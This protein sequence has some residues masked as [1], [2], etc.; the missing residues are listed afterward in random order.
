MKSNNKLSS[1]NHVT[2]TKATAFLKW[3][4]KL[5]FI[6]WL[7]LGFTNLQA[8]TFPVPSPAL[9]WQKSYWPTTHPSTVTQTREQSGEDWYYTITLSKSNG[10][11]NGWMCGGYNTYPE[12]DFIESNGGC[13][14]LPVKPASEYDFS[15]FETPGH[16]K[17]GVVN[18]ISFVD[19]DGNRLWHKN[20]LQGEIT[21]I[22]QTSDGNFLA[23]GNTMS[24]R[25][26]FNGNQNLF[27]NQT[28]NTQINNYFKESD[29]NSKNTRKICLIKIDPQGNLIWQKLFGMEDFVQG[30]S[31]GI[32]KLA[33]AS[34]AYG[35]DVVEIDEKYY[36]T[37]KASAATSLTDYDNNKFNTKAFI[38]KINADGFLLDKSFL[39]NASLRYHGGTIAYYKD[40]SNN[41][42]IAVANETKNE[43]TSEYSLEFNILD[44]A[45]TVL[46][47]FYYN[48]ESDKSKRVWNIT[49]NNNGNLLVPLVHNCGDCWSSGYHGKGATNTLSVCK[50]D[51]TT[52]NNLA[53]FPKYF[54]YV[55]AYDLRMGI[56]NTKDGGFA[57]VTSKLQPDFNTGDFTK[58][59]TS[60]NNS[61]GILFNYEKNGGIN[62]YYPGQEGYEFWQTNTYVAKCA[63]DGTLE[64]DKNF[65][66][67]TLKQA[68]PQANWDYTNLK[69]DLK[70]AEC[71]YAIVQND[72]ES[73][74]LAGNNSANFDDDYLVKINGDCDMRTNNFDVVGTSYPMTYKLTTNE[75]WN[76]SKKVLG[77]VIIPYGKTLTI[78]GT[79]TTNSSNN[80][81]STTII[82]FADSRK[83]NSR[84]NIIVEPGGELII[85]GAMLTSLIS[86]A[87]TNSKWDGILVEGNQSLNQFSTSN[88]GYVQL[89][90]AIIENAINGI[91]TSSYTFGADLASTINWSKTGGG[92][93]K[94]NNTIFR[95]NKRHVEFMAYK[96]NITING[97][98]QEYDNKSS[99]SN[100]NF[101]LE[102]SNYINSDNSAQRTMVT[103]WGVKGV[104]FTACDFKNNTGAINADKEFYNRGIGIYTLDASLVVDGSINTNDCS[105]IK[106]G[107]FNDL[108]AGIINKWSTGATL[109]S[110]YRYLDFK[111][112]D[113]SIWIASGNTA[114][115]H[116]SKFD[117]NLPANYYNVAN[118]TNSNAFNT[119]VVGI[120]ANEMGAYVIENNEFT[121]ASK[122]DKIIVG[123]ILHNSDV[124]PTGAKVR[125]NTYEGVALGSQTQ[126]NNFGLA[127]T[128]NKYIDIVTSAVKM[129]PFTTTSN[130]PFFGNCISVSN[131]KDYKNEFT[132]MASNLSDD[133]INHLAVTKTYVVAPT[134]INPPATAKVVNVNVTTCGTLSNTITEKEACTATP[135]L[136]CSN[137]VT[138]PNDAKTK[139]SLGKTQIINLNNAINSGNLTETG[140]Q[141][142]LAEK[143]YFEREVLQARGEVLW[144]F[145]KMGEIDSTVNSTDSIIAFLT[146]ENDAVSKKLL[147]ATYYLAGKYNDANNVLSELSNDGSA[148]MTNFIAYYTLL[149]NANQVNR[150]I[151]QLTAG[152][153]TNMEQIA[154]S[155]S[156]AAESAKGILTLVKGNYYDVYIERAI[157][158]GGLGKTGKI[159]ATA[160]ENTKQNTNNALTV[161]PNPAQNSIFIRLNNINTTEENVISLIDVTGKIVLTKKTNNNGTIEIDTQNLSNGVY[162]VQL[163]NATLNIVSKI[164]ITH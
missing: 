134:A 97:K 95:N 36:I 137:I 152:E 135:S 16:R 98:T 139:L 14:D 52:G 99:F 24:T 13:L 45:L 6:L 43:T 56:T 149:I 114:T 117:L 147:V 7:V 109:M 22:I 63:A 159:T 130:T 91:S 30:T 112:I 29:C 116:G 46:N 76:T 53:G 3:S 49:F 50:F 118:G 19:L 87:G 123:S 155:N 88:Q 100:C 85:N 42:K 17:G 1:I 128:C 153:W 44:D 103:A 151:F 8:Q 161:Y 164:V 60:I 54:G 163:A 73:Y 41:I 59:T 108:S 15:E 72:D 78:N 35:Y 133:I 115:I 106:W 111:K 28:S 127:L 121:D 140:M 70:T 51:I 26:L 136:S 125:L 31:E 64:W 107:T 74:T 27:Y 84:T 132:S 148:E 39:G 23:V 110:T 79:R 157:S 82:E 156:S 83:T 113:R 47:T 61:K 62:Y 71:M 4:C 67:N 89:N 75:V 101:E 141:E 126:F 129:N 104:R 38:M 92:I 154:A 158:T 65:E 33:Y 143:K 80:I 66:A 105:V 57:I 48:I 162:F 18:Q 102:G 9:E 145:N 93:I 150:N 32:N 68:G 55:T 94:A 11:Q 131:R 77:S 86:C 119:G 2:N 81:I 21:R 25:D 58:V 160:P 96:N 146:T 10:V 138:D 90:N 142:A 120:F 124:Q 5:M 12:W 34:W 122:K 69:Y 40:V 37:G 144:A 20:F